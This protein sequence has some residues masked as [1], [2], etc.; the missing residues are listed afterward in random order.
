MAT[1]AVQSGMSWQRC[2]PKIGNLELDVRAI[3]K[4]PMRFPSDFWN[5]DYIAACEAENRQ[6]D[7]LTYI[8]ISD[9]GQSNLRRS[10]VRRQRAV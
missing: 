6:P 5:L 2:G 10:P 1:L 9:A 7:G 8:L 4:I 3:A